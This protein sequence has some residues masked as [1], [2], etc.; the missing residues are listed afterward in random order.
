VFEQCSRDEAT[1][2]SQL[3]AEWAQ[4]G[5]ADQKI[6]M[7]E[8][9]TGGFASYV[10]LLTCLEM[11]RDVASPNTNPNDPHAKSGS[12]PTRPDQTDVTVGEAHRH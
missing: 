8:T 9:T 7:G 1:A 12:R 2:L 5:R 6:C 10:E 3:R 4:L 11:A